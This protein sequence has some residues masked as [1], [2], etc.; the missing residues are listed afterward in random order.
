[1][2]WLD[3]WNKSLESV[4]CTNG[5]M[6]CADHFE[7]ET[8]NIKSQKYFLKPFAVPTIFLPMQIQ[9]AK[10]TTESQ[11]TISNECSNSNC[12]SAEKEIKFLRECLSG[13]EQEKARVEKRLQILIDEQSEEIMNLKEK[14]SRLERINTRY[15]SDF[16]RY[17]VDNDPKVFLILLHFN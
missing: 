1:M 11:V 5:N 2:D 10:E 17:V 6:I 12:L 3:V 9:T 13:F 15:Q 16:A 7:N 14:V 8:Y 4:P